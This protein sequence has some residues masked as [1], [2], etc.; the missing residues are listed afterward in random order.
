M[1]ALWSTM[2]SL[3]T[4]Y[5]LCL[6][7]FKMFQFLATKLI[8]LVLKSLTFSYCYYIQN[9]LVHSNLKAHVFQEAVHEDGCIFKKI[10]KHGILLIELI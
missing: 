10:V 2:S 7:V 5:N 6:V 8:D 9:L 1:T 4:C 3:F